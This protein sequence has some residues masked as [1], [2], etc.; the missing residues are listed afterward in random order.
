[1]VFECLDIGN[2]K[3]GEESKYAGEEKDFGDMME[4]FLVHKQQQITTSTPMK[5]Q[6]QQP[7]SEVKS[8]EKEMLQDVT[9][10]LEKLGTSSP[11]VISAV[12][13]PGK[14]I[15][16]CSYRHF[17]SFIFFLHKMHFDF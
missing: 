4:D 10:Q 8:A 16:I 14:I 6:K 13:K 11:S 12:H 5:L 2:A 17:F 3:K 15:C 7:L 1:M 9:Q